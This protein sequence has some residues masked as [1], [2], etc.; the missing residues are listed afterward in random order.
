MAD[1]VVLPGVGDTVATDDIGGGVQAQQIKVLAGTDGVAE[2]IGS[3][4]KGTYQTFWVT[5]RPYAVT[6]QQNSSS[7]TIAT[8][9]YN[10]GDTVGAGWTFTNFAR[11]TGEGGVINGVALADRGDVTSSITLYFSSAAVSF[12]SD[13]VAPVIS[14]A[15]LD[16]LL[17]VV[18]VPLADLGTGRFGAVDSIAIPYFC[19]ATSLFVYAVT[20]TANSFFAAATDLRLRLFATLD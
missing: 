14:D 19:A 18:T 4:D 7:L 15:D 6:Q 17:G 16:L 2:P 11:A 10:I 20:N 13:N 9:A 3:D 12:G 1:N 5:E 8:T